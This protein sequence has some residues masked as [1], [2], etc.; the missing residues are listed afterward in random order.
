MSQSSSLAVAKYETLGSLAIRQ[1][2][3]CVQ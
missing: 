1:L 2:T 3:R